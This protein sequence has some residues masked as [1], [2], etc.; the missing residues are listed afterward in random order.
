MKE[1]F[2]VKGMT[3]SACSA[4]IERTVRRLNGV[5]K[6]DVSLML[7]SMIVEYDERVLSR[8]EI[9]QAVVDLG[10]QASLFDES[11]VDDL[12]P[13]HDILKKRF[14][15]SLIFCIIFKKILL[16]TKTN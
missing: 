6:A 1:K 11:A 5:E 7:E 2:S 4:G 8:E 13:Q 14:F 16:K 12:K 3:C 10:Y 9:M 15:I